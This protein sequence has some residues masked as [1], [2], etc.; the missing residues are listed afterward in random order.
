MALSQEEFDAIIADETKRIVG[1]VAWRPDPDR[2][3]AY[4]FRV[5]LEWDQEAALEVSGY[6]RSATER[7]TYTL[8]HDRVRI[9]GL[10]LGDASHNNLDGTRVDGSHFHFWSARYGRPEARA[11]TSISGGYDRPKL[12]WEQFC[13]ELRIVHQGELR[14]TIV[15]EAS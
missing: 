14:G 4:K 10:D 5:A 15:E 11:A 8:V 1:D 9:A 2:A 13:R 3:G 7:L 12:V 6:Q